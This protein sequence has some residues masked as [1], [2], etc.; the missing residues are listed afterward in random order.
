MTRILIVED[1]ADI[2]LGLEED[3]RRHG[4][5][6]QHAADGQ[7]ALKPGLAESCDIVLLDVMLP[8]VDGFEVCQLLRR[9]GARTPVILLTAKTQEAEKVLG[10]ECGADDYVTKPFSPK[11]LR[12]RIK[13][14]LR[15]AAHSMPELFSFGECTVDFE[16]AE[17]RRSG[18]TVDL[19]ATEFRLLKAFIESAG[20]LLT[21]ERVIELAWPPGT[22]ITD[23]V[24]DTHLWNMRKKLEADPGNP[25]HF[26]AVR[27]LGYRFEP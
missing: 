7:A 5:E 4:F 25:R 6:T 15:R 19:T 13:A 18:A 27:G 8:K 21:R 22:Y 10:F 9:R 24:V 26:I 16:R 20:R 17:V 1:E 11:E 3:L 23:R 14:V 12:A 2:V